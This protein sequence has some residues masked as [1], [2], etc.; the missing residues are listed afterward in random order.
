MPQDHVI[1]IKGIN[2]LFKKRLRLDNK[3]L[4]ARS[5]DKVKWKISTSEVE[6]IE[7]I[8]EKKGIIN[9]WEQ[10]PSIEN[11]WEGIVDANA[12][13]NYIYKYNISWKKKNN[14]KSYTHDPKISIN[15]S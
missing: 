10:R 1:Q 13:K 2:W 12:P 9:V 8:T 4:K 5:G 6:S 14:G 3:R 15:P 11:Q 7:G